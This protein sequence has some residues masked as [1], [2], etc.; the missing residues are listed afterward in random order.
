M[1]VEVLDDFNQPKTA[2]A[3]SEPGR[4]SES[5]VIAEPDVDADADLNDAILQQL[6]KDML[7]NFMKPEPSVQPAASSAADSAQPDDIEKEINELSQQLQGNDLQTSFLK[8]LIAEAM[9][10]RD[11]EG[12]GGGGNDNSGDTASPGESFQDTIQRTMERMQESGER[13]TAALAQDDESTDLV[14][15]LLKAAAT[16]EAP[17]NENVDLN[18]ILMRA[19]EQIANK[20]LLYEP[21]QELHEKFGPWIAENKGKGKVSDEEMARYEY[22]AQVV[23]QIVT[24][25]NEEGY[26]D[27]NPECRAYIWEKVQEVCCT[28]A[29]PGL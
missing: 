12:D 24:K 25:F 5:A 10:G 27:G 29:L 7:A 17:S 20:E 21:M 26:S 6:E 13:T 14:S 19:M 16:R 28:L 2:D 4:P 18:D 15:Q 9:S 23:E 8:A 11:P 1:T 3:A 22:Q